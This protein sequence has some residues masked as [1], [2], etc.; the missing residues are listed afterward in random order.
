MEKMSNLVWSRH[1]R[2][3]RDDRMLEILLGDGLGEIID[4]RLT[5]G[6]VKKCLTDT[7][8]C[9]IVGENHIV[10]TAYLITFDQ[11]AVFYDG[12]KIPKEVYRTLLHNY[13]KYSSLKNS[14]H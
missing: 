14:K 7:G 8:C 12:M 5:A 4:E 1:I 6:G 10:I 2:E 13:K 3:E 9:L 11:V